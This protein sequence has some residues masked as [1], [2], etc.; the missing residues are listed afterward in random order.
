MERK[1]ESEFQNNNESSMDC[2]VWKRFLFI[3]ED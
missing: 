3:M 2:Y 1:I